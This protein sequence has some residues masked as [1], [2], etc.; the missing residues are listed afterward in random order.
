MEFAYAHPFTLAAELLENG[1]PVDNVRFIGIDRFGNIGIIELI[2][3]F[4]QTIF[5]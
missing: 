3:E 4:F 5:V 2:L 1:I